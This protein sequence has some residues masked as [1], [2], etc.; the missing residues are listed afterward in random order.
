MGSAGSVGINYREANDAL[1]KKDFAHCLKISRKE[2]KEILHCLELIEAA[3][4]SFKKEVKAFYQEATELKNIFFLL[5]IERNRAWILS[6][7]CPPAGGEF[8]ICLYL[9]SWLLYLYI[10]YIFLIFFYEKF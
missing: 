10:I 9:V 6:I 1:G 4:S 7:A 2:V 3:N 5:L 8:V